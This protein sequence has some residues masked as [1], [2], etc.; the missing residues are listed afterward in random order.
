MTAE[1]VADEESVGKG[2]EERAA[3]DTSE[4][5]NLE[6]RSREANWNCE[7]EDEGVRM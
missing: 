7:P 3:K 2:K 4:L 1:K 6:E 5:E